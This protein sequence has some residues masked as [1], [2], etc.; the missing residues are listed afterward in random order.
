[1]ASRCWTH[2]WQRPHVDA[3]LASPFTSPQA[4]VSVAACTSRAMQTYTYQIAM[5]ESAHVLVD[6]D[7]YSHAL[8]WGYLHRNSLL[9]R[10][11]T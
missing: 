6:V 7:F 4:E 11:H 3:L 10:V 8:V 1:M 2:L 9:E 5:L